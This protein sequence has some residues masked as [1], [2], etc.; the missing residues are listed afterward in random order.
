MFDSALCSSMRVREEPLVDCFALQ[1]LKALLSRFT[2]R[3]VVSQQVHGVW[4]KISAEPKN[5]AI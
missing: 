1:E 4:S 3:S 5:T 2:C